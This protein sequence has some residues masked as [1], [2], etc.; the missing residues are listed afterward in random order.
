MKLAIRNWP[1]LVC[2]SAFG[3]ICATGLVAQTQTTPVS[4]YAQATN[5]VAMRVTPPNAQG[6]ADSAQLITAVASGDYQTTLEILHRNGIAE[7]TLMAMATNL[8]NSP[9]AAELKEPFLKASVGALAVNDRSLKSGVQNTLDNAIGAL[10][11]ETPTWMPRR[12]DT[13]KIASYDS[14]FVQC[15]SAPILVLNI[16][17]NDPCFIRYF[18]LYDRYADYVHSV[19]LNGPGLSNSK[20]NQTNY[21]QASLTLNALY[22][23]IKAREPNAFVWLSVAKEDNHSDEQWLKAMTFRPD[24]LQISNLRQFHSPFAETRARY[25][26]IVG[27]NMPM[28]VAGFEGYSAA[29]RQQAQIFTTALENNDTPARASAINQLGGIGSV[30]GQDLKQEET[31]LQAL[32]YC[33]ISVQWTLLAAL[34]NT[35]KAPPANK[36]NL[37]NP[38]AGLLDIYCAQGD[39]AHA[40]SFAAGMISSSSPGDLNWTVGN[41]YEGIALLSQAPPDPGDAIPKLDQIL[42]FNYKNL[43]G[44]DHYIIGAVKWRIYAA[45]LVGDTQLA[46]KLVQWVQNQPL[47]ADMK[48][49]F[50]NQYKDYL[51]PT[52]SP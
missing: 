11:Y 33:G 34:A 29:V 36:S 5:N 2:L 46:P 1:W 48:S 32:G 30:V 8:V 40:V 37:V 38:R 42:A 10:G 24:G 4:A 7:D 45:H 12:P 16:R 51:P 15:P 52:T 14:D 39:Y 13:W 44:R 22:Q 31:N 25:Q 9:T 18:E 28:M 41:L 47:R 49:A 21:V 50:L 3:L 43:P 27:T 17:L 23:L 26:S 6:A 20:L 35:N 19:V